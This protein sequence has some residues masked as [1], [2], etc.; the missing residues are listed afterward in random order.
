MQKK[1][2]Q[3]E[4]KPADPNN[5]AP[6]QERIDKVKPIWQKLP[7]D[8]R[9][10]ILTMS[11]EELAEQAQQADDEFAADAQSSDGLVGAHLGNTC[12]TRPSACMHRMR[13]RLA[14]RGCP[15]MH[16][17]QPNMGMPFLMHI[18]AIEAP[19]V[20][21]RSGPQRPVWRPA[22]SD[23]CTRMQKQR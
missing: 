6:S 2:S 5:G 15:A 3:N 18:S 1:S 10:E 8:K 16:T 13:T 14:A 12:I 20:P 4:R 22:A 23:D 7:H 21:V 19:D 11:T 9:L 17:C